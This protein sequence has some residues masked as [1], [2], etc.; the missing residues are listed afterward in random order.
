M[1]WQRNSYLILCQLL[2]IALFSCHNFSKLKQSVA[3]KIYFPKSNTGK[4]K[5]TGLE[6]KTSKLYF[7]WKK[8]YSVSKNGTLCQLAA[9]AWWT[10]VFRNLRKLHNPRFVIHWTQR[11]YFIVFSNLYHNEHKCS[12]K[13][14]MTLCYLALRRHRWIGRAAD[15]YRAECCDFEP[16]SDGHG[17]CRK[18]SYNT[19]IWH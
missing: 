11:I 9:P 19:I 1:S 14:Y 5:L 6:E 17:P 12:C 15:P 18:I 7:R 2:C 10:H 8:K 4:R 16:Q 3:L 13:V